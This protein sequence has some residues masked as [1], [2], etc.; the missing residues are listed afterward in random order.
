M[1]GCP[2]ALFLTSMQLNA[3]FRAAKIALH[4]IGLAAAVCTIV[5]D[6]A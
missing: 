2:S 6:G 3:R 5:R 1:T 4:L